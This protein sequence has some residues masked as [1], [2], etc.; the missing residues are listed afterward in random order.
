MFRTLCVTAALSLTSAASAQT[1]RPIP[2]PPVQTPP[3]TESA[4]PEGYAPIP[5]WAG[6]TRAPKPAKTAAFDVETFATGIAGGFSF[7][8][9]PDG[10]IILSER[11]GRIKIVGKDGKVSDPIAGLPSNF[12]AAGGQGLNEATPDREFAKN[13]VVYL[14]YTVLPDGK[15]P[16]PPQRSPG[17]L[18]VA[19]AHLSADDTRLDDVKVLLNA[20]G[21]GGRLIQAPDSTLFITSTVPAG[22]GI[23]STDWMQPQQLD[24]NM[25]KVLR[26]NADGSIPK[27]NPFVGRAG[28]HPEIYALGF[29]DDQGV[30]IHPR[31]GKLWISEHGPRGG[32][33]INA[34]EKGKNYGHPMIS[35]GHDYSGKPLGD[36]KTSAPGMEQPAYFW[37]PDVAPAG[38]TFYSGRLFPA[39]QGDLFIGALVVGEERLLVDLKARIRGV[40]QGPDG[41]LYVLVDGNDGKILKL[42]PKK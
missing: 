6:Q 22:T 26:I 17:I 35:Y 32:D 34:I 33:E 12:F 1:P 21:T 40:E 41:A 5:E 16:V 10:R 7:H 15:M 27:D 4:A 11:P 20:E 8:F 29:R 30:A 3:A 14:L 18:T 13:R 31:T 42:V 28:A 24:S 19:S 38:M 39:W 25:G 23:V 36:G 2:R 37:T 9:L